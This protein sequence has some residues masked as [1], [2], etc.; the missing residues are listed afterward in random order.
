MSIDRQPTKVDEQG[1]FAFGVLPK[2]RAC[3]LVVEAPGFGTASLPVAAAEMQTAQLQLPPIKLK[4][5][6]QKL[7]GKVVGPDDKPMA[8]VTVRINGPGQPN[9]G[10]PTDANGHFAL[11]VCEGTVRVMVSVQPG[12]ANPQFLSGSAQA[13][14]GDTNLLLKLAPRPAARGTSPAPPAQPLSGR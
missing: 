9:D 11:K 5:A 10:A 6:D 8:G 4:P 14:G 13:R 2:G 7:E 1:S 12:A 3:G